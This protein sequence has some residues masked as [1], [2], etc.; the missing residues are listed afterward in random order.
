VAAVEEVLD[1]LKAQARPEQLEGMARFAMTGERRLGVSV[2]DMRRIARTAGKDHRLALALWQT[3]IPE[4]MMVAS[5]VDRPE[6]ITE[7]QME[8]WV[9]NLNAW[10]VCDQVCMNLF[11]KTPL[12][13]GKIREWSG[14]EEEF[15]KRAAF[16]LIASLAVHDKKAPDESFIQLMP[17]IQ[18]GARDERNFVK[19][20]VSWAL[21]SIGKRNPHLQGVALEAARELRDMESKS[22]KW[23]AADA[24]R[25]L[26]G[27]TTQRR[28]QRQGASSPPKSSSHR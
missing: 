25:D 3:G 9:K 10:D 4:A 14:R 16:A 19:K 26:A 11:D 15:V 8:A 7:A 21:R 23:V 22:A 13:W 5:M 20:A 2:P 24:I 27:E 28:L 17:L 18:A 6:E 1:M 12:A